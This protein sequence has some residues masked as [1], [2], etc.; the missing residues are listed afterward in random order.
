MQAAS[1]AQPTAQFVSSCT[2]KASGAL[3]GKGLWRDKLSTMAPQTFS[4][5]EM[6]KECCHLLQEAQGSFHKGKRIMVFCIAL[7]SCQVVN[8][9]ISVQEPPYPHTL[10]QEAQGSLRKGRRVM[11]F[12]N[13]LGSCRAVDFAFAEASVPRVAYHGDVPLDERKA[14]LKQFNQPSTSGK[15]AEEVP[16]LMVCTDIAAR[17]AIMVMVSCLGLRCDQGA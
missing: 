17:Y 8:I 12:C 14:A 13:T 1:A 5:M 11:V 10:V 6:C 7:G 9:F 15:T 3:P 16:R 4:L 2:S